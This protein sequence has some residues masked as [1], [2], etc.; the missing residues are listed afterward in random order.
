MLL[1]KQSLFC[2]LR[3]NLF[4][5]TYLNECF[6]AVLSNILPS[7]LPSC[8]LPAF[9]LHP[10]SRGHKRQPFS[11]KDE[12]WI[13]IS[14]EKH[15]YVKMPKLCQMMMP[16]WK[17]DVLISNINCICVSCHYDTCFV[18]VFTHRCLWWIPCN[19]T[20]VENTG[21]RSWLY[22]KSFLQ[23]YLSRYIPKHQARMETK[24]N[25][26]CKLL[27]GKVVC[28]CIWKGQ[29]ITNTSVYTCTVCKEV[30]SWMLVLHGIGGYMFQITR[31]YSSR[32]LKHLCYSFVPDFIYKQL[33]NANL[34]KYI[35]RSPLG[36][37]CWD[38]CKWL[39]PKFFY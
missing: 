20:P 14:R 23:N 33:T 37:V 32:A 9:L 4:I 35:L 17:C 24:L 2:Y 39:Q 25:S 12:L 15:N 22:I 8:F 6:L 21:Y 10:L 16:R 18:A 1:L 26:R 19:M 13:P 30:T 34:Q 7:C 27:K 28:V 38:I 5:W 29:T 36:F 31:N 3:V 11:V